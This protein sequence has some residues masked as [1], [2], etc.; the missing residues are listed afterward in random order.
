M[1]HL[2]ASSRA[3]SLRRPFLGVGLAVACAG[4]LQAQ[5]QQW[6]VQ[7]GTGKFDLAAG[8]VPDG[9]G[10]VFVAGE[11]VGS[12]VTALDTLWV[13][14]LDAGG[15][16]VW[17]VPF[18]SDEQ[19]GTRGAASDGAG[20]LYVAGV[21]QGDVGG[22]FAGGATDGWIARFDAGGQ[23]L[24]AVQLGSPYDEFVAGLASD[25]SGGAFVAGTR[26][27]AGT[28]EDGW[29]VH[30][31]AS[32]AVL[33]QRILGT[34]AI[35]RAHDVASDGSG[36]VFVCGSTAG[37]LAGPSSGND[38]VWW[39]RL[40]ASGTTLWT[41]QVGSSAFDVVD[42]ATSDGQGGFYACGTTGGDV[43]GTPVGGFDAFV[44]HVDGAGNTTW[45]RQFGST[46]T[47]YAHGCS[48]T[49]GGDL[50]VSGFTMGS[51]AGPSA[52]QND[53]W[54]AR[55]TPNGDMLWSHQFGSSG[56]EQA[57]CVLAGPGSTVFAGG[58]TNGAFGGVP[59]PQP[60]AWVARFDDSCGWGAS[61]CTASTTSI[62]GCAA[63]L[64]SS[65]VANL[66]SPSAFSFT[67]GAVPGGNIGLSI[68]GDGGTTSIPF[69][70]LGGQICI[71]GAI[72]RSAPK[73]GGG[74]NG[75][76]NGAFTFTLQDLANASSVVAPGATLYAQV[77]ARDPVNP[78]GF[79]LSDG[80]AFTVC[81]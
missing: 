45:I 14:R 78:D 72:V 4:A 13:R 23:M 10:G 42:G 5:A 15:N 69:G 9:S 16:L 66:A 60:N 56:S 52:G 75:Q 43:G 24:W 68:F 22:P 59:D 7:Y 77:W 41:R 44:V 80:L 51:W 46:T 71:A 32:G 3:P 62:P 8:L 20:G 36:G 49:P 54:L 57:L 79:L 18:G 67:S 1:K 55:I 38:D 34:T 76:C 31:D 70:T 39:A 2:A 58:L 6:V 73:Q 35:D 40:D 27:N 37:D 25:G 74:S 26:K 17:H 65:G 11:S 81:P 64:S 53:A 30:I 21:T 48:L 28:A 33:W 12:P 29:V 63:A 50:V 61:Y 19:E 47:D